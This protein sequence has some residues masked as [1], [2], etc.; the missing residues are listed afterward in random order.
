MADLSGLNR[1]ERLAAYCRGSA[2]GIIIAC[3]TCGAEHFREE[4][5]LE[6]P[7]WESCFGCNETGKMIPM[8][9]ADL[10]TLWKPLWRRLGQKIK[11]ED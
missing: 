4:A 1:D 6:H 2:G 11:G 7:E 8:L 3:I 5:A 9:K 10:D